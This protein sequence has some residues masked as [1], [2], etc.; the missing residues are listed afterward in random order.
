MSKY[1]LTYDHNHEI[2]V[3]VEFHANDGVTFKTEEFTEMAKNIALHIVAS[4]PGK[5]ANGQEI[6]SLLNQRYIKDDTINVRN[7][8]ASVEKILKANLKVTRYTRYP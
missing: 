5:S 2:G 8:I 7:Y 1:I 4:D 3:L 6:L